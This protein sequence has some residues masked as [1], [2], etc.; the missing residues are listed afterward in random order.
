MMPGS[1]NGAICGGCARVMNAENNISAAGDLP[2]NL[3]NT[4]SYNIRGIRQFVIFVI[5][6]YGREI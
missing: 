6:M 2:P 5:E 4:F 1:T 3:P